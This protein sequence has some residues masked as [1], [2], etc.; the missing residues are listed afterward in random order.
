[1]DGDKIGVAIR[2][3]G[4]IGAVVIVHPA[5]ATPLAMAPRREGTL[6]KFRLTVAKFLDPWLKQKKREGSTITALRTGMN[7]LCETLGE[8]L[9][10][11]VTPKLVWPTR[12]S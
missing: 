11:S 1:M 9:L 5:F 6:G 7:Y 8:K 10:E 2:L 4:N 3:L 12:I